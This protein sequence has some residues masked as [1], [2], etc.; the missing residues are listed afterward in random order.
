MH[1]NQFACAQFACARLV[2]V[3]KAG[4]MSASPKGMMQCLL[5]PNWIRKAVFHR[6]W[7]GR[8]IGFLL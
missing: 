1:V 2:C 5:Q 6:L 7:I 8:G 3:L 4:G